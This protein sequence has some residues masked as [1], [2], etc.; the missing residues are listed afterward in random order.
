MPSHPFAA[1]VLG[2]AFGGKTFKLKFGH[3]GGNH[4]L[5]HT[6]TGACACR[7][8]LLLP[9]PPLMLH[10]LPPRRRCGALAAAAALAATVAAAAAPSLH[11]LPLWP[12]AVRRPPLPPPP[13]PPRPH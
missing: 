11:L 4:P 6:P 2:Q 8:L 10:P 12:A 1:Q 13:F 9:P 5:R 3:H 7:L